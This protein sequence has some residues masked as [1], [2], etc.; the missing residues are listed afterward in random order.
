MGLS[1]K[2]GVK[3]CILHVVSEKHRKQKE[4]DESKICDQPSFYNLAINLP[5]SF[6]N[7]TQMEI[8]S[9]LKLLL[10]LTKV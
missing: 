2:N 8:K 9:G 5:L 4:E 6:K 7:K 1:L 10:L 3:S